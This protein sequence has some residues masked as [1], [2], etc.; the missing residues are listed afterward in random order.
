MRFGCFGCFG[1]YRRSPSNSGSGRERPRAIAGSRFDLDRL[2]GGADM[3]DTLREYRRRRSGRRSQVLRHDRALRRR[4]SDG[5]IERSGPL[6]RFLHSGGGHGRRN[7]LTAKWRNYGFE[8]GFGIGI[9]HGYATLGRIGFENREYAAIGVV[10]NLAARQRRSQAA[11]ACRRMK[12][13]CASVNFDRFMLLPRP[14]ARIRH[15]AKLEFSSKDRSRKPEAGHARAIRQ[16][17][18]S[19]CALHTLEQDRRVG[20]GIRNPGESWASP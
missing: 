9:A 3:V 17:E 2:G 19:L 20:R 12:A 16:L 5:A 6:P 13:I 8:L 18:L 11:P 7:E 15:A 14:A 4:R 10:P 1:R